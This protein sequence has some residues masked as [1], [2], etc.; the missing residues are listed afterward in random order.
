[1]PNTGLRETEKASNTIPILSQ[2]YHA[3]LD[4]VVIYMR[5]H[6]T[7]N[8]PFFAVASYAV[9]SVPKRHAMQIMLQ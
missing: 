5:N 9:L 4:V 1:M 3:L 2:V 8:H 6:H 7:S